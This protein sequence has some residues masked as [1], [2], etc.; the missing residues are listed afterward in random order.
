MD[1]QD[2]KDKETIYK[3]LE[4]NLDFIIDAFEDEILGRTPTDERVLH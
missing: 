2:I 3:E 1:E 4:K